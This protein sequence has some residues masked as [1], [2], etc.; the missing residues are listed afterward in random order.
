V[1]NMF[2][3]E[4][5]ELFAIQSEVFYPRSNQWSVY[6]DQIKNSFLDKPG[7]R[8]AFRQLLES[9]LKND[10]E[11]AEKKDLLTSDERLNLL[12]SAADLLETLQMGIYLED[13]H[14]ARY[15]VGMEH[16]IRKA[17][18][19][20]TDLSNMFNEYRTLLHSEQ[21]KGKTG[22]LSFLENNPLIP[23]INQA[24]VI[25]I[26]FDGVPSPSSLTSG[27]CDL[28]FFDELVMPPMDTWFAKDA[29]LIAYGRGPNDNPFAFWDADE[30]NLS[31]EF[32]KIIEGAMSRCLKDKE[33]QEF[34]AFCSLK[35]L[36][37]SPEPSTYCFAL[38]HVGSGCGNKVA[39]SE[40]IMDPEDGVFIPSGSAS[41]G[42]SE[43]A[44]FVVMRPE[45]RLRRL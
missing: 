35:R 22:K 33:C 13:A 45:G 39:V 19:R 27:S 41:R 3:C 29:N 28:G 34:I 15:N 12:W 32:Q 38:K 23:G 5:A 4:M 40:D 37:E 31:A 43:E 30:T 24:I 20:Q 8:S 21:N 18:E 16:R 42:H 10:N 25:K 2:L 7:R 9:F 14:E 6:L 1:K 11:D 26:G 36:P 17:A 44:V